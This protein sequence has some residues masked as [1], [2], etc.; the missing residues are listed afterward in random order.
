MARHDRI[1]DPAVRE[2][3]QEAHRDMLAGNNTEAVHI[4][5]DVFLDVLK[6][7]PQ[8]V[9]GEVGPMDQ[10]TQ[11]GGWVDAYSAELKWP[12]IGANLVPEAEEEGRFRIDYSTDTF[13]FSQAITYYE[14]AVATAIK[15]GV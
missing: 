14:F 12:Q 8:I 2:R 3:F 7:K 10:V 6:K 4:L 1:A 11:H 13:S 15:Y 9:H 5:S